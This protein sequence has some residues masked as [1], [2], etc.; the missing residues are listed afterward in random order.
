MKDNERLEFLGDAVLEV[1]S[2]EFLFKEYPE[3]PE[4]DLTKLRASIVC[5]PT[6]A[7]CARDLNLGDTYFLGKV[8]SAPEEEEE[9][10]I[11]SDAMEAFIGPFI[12]MVVLL[13]AKEFIDRF[14]MKEH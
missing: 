3:M 1:I 14:I 2:S 6:L 11:V 9:I 4:G 13:M 8:R 12:W 7:L 5:E 10:P